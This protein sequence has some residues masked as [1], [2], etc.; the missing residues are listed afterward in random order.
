MVAGGVLC[1]WRSI[2]VGSGVIVAV[3]LVRSGVDIPEPW[4]SVYCAAIWV[5]AAFLV[6]K[7]DALAGALFVGVALPSVAFA[8][9]LIPE[10]VRWWVD[11]PAVFLALAAGAYNGRGP[12]IVDY[13]RPVGGRGIVSTMEAS[14]GYTARNSEDS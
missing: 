9:G 14:Q 5:F 11:E 8:L 4:F 3:L 2:S 6:F 12:G 13:V 7:V 10:Q 1:L